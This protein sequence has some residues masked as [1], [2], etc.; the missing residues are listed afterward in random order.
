MVVEHQNQ[1]MVIRLYLQIMAL[2][3]PVLADAKGGKM[4]EDSGEDNMTAK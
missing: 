3:L 1:E 2:P 4:V